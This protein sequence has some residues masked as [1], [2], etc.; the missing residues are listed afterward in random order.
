MNSKSEEAERLKQQLGIASYSGLYSFFYITPHE[1]RHE[2]LIPLLTL[3]EWTPI[4]RKDAAFLE[5]DEQ[6][7]AASQVSEFFQKGNP[8]SINGSEV[9]PVVA[10]VNFFG[11]DIRDFAMN[12]EPRRVSVAQAR[13]GI[14]LSYP[15][16]KG[17]PSKIRAKW[18]TFSKFAPFL[19]STI[20]E[21]NKPAIEHF[22]RPDETTF[23][24]SRHECS[25]R[26]ST[27]SAVESGDRER[28]VF[29]SS[30]QAETVQP[31]AHS[32]TCLSGVRLSRRKEKHTTPSTQ[33]SKGLCY[34]R[35][36]CRFAARC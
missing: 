36:T 34:V 20:Y 26:Q 24:W 21:F 7:A 3:D 25:V 4:K 16:G 6:K 13:V 32:R 8:V 12:A 10:R 29:R 33:S 30:K 1:V 17:V 2:I 27:E 14:M 18:E 15:S 11:L 19:K 5:I 35:C 31:F 22:F 23:E 9:N 28:S